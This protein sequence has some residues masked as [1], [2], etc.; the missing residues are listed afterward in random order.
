MKQVNI[1]CEHLTKQNLKYNLQTYTGKLWRVQS[2]RKFQ[3]HLNKKNKIAWYF[4]CSGN[5]VRI[6]SSLRQSRISIVATC[7]I[8]NIS[9]AQ[10][11]C[12]QES[13]RI[14]IIQYE[15]VISKWFIKN[16]NWI[17]WFQFQIF[18][19]FINVLFKVFC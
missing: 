1:F 9:L 19:S 18:H 6:C 16:I 5:M 3:K 10:S 7:C 4:A 2:L 11:I 13:S 17:E 8:E 15:T 12:L 14:L